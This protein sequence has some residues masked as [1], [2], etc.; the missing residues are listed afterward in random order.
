MDLLKKF[1]T[2]RVSFHHSDHPISLTDRS[3]RA[4]TLPELCQRST[5]PYHPSL[6]L[7]NG[8]LQTVWTA[9]KR[10]EVVV[11]YKRQIFASEN[12][13]YPGTF[14]VDFVSQ[15]DS[16]IKQEDSSLP[17]HTT[18]FRDADAPTGSADCRPMLVALHG[19]AGGSHEPYVKHVLAPL[20]ACG[21]EA[22][23]VVSRG[24]GGTQLTGRLLYNARSTWDL[25]QTVAFLRRKFPNRPLYA[26]GFSIG[27]NILVN[28]LGEEG[29]RCG[30]RAAVV[31]SNPWNLE[32]V[33][34]ALRRSWMGLNVYSHA[35]ANGMK[36]IVQRHAEMIL[37]N[38]R[39]AA[40][41]VEK[42]RFFFDF[43]SAVQLPMWGYPTRGT[44]YRDA[45]SVDSVLAVKVPLFALNAED[46]PISHH[47]ALPFEEFQK[48]PLH[49]ALH[50]VLRRSPWLVISFLKA[51][52]HDIDWTKGLE[53]ASHVPEST[54][55]FEYHPV[56]RRI[57]P[58]TTAYFPGQ[59]EVI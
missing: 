21:W 16:D 38:R 54:H 3:N 53:P 52:H 7:F 27:A 30:I 4:V 45:S 33:D 26:V 5:P 50:N 22:C 15:D 17:P 8:H 40:A 10:T 6:I 51:L 18:Y 59:T 35:M 31:C 11:R 55:Y 36:Q 57:Q 34:H 1:W 12:D 24:C 25:K 42:I 2:A 32:V 29:E 23:V 28:Y 56:R 49:R 48:K 44:Y 13:L 43:D 14:A 46:D 41:A 20:A 47:E 19:V 9:L 39:I 37:R 58:T